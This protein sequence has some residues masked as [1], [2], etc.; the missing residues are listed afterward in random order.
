MVKSNSGSGGTGQSPQA[1]SSCFM[2]A[3]SHPLPHPRWL[4]MF[5]ATAVSAN[6]TFHFH[7][8]SNGIATAY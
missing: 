4:S 1:A 3:P 8:D 5:A 6:K 2:D 7:L